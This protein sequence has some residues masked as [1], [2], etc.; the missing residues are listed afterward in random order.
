MAIALRAGR[1]SN[2][3]AGGTTLTM[4]VPTG[5]TD[6]DV[7]VMAI[8]ARG[9]SGTAISIPLDSWGQTS[10]PF[11][12]NYECVTVAYGG[13]MWVAFANRVDLAASVLCATSPDGRNWTI[14]SDHPWTTEGA[15]VDVAYDGSGTWVA[16]GWG[17]SA[18]F[19]GSATNPAGTWTDRSSGTALLYGAGI[20][21]GGGYWVATAEI[22]AYYEVSTNG[23][24]WTY[25]TATPAVNNTK[26]GY[27]G[28]YYVCG[29]HFGG[30]DRG[31][32]YLSTIGSTW[33]TKSLFSFWGMVDVNGA[34]YANGIWVA[35]GADGKMATA[36]NPTGTWTS[37]TSSFGTDEIFDVAY[38]ADGV[39]V[40]VGG[41]GKIATATDPTGTWTQQ[42]SGFSTSAVKAVGHGKWWVI[43]GGDGKVGTSSWA[44]LDRQ[45]S[46]TTLAQAFYWRIAT[47]EPSSYVFT[48]TSNKASGV[49]MSV[50]GADELEPA[51]ER[52][53][54]GVNASSASVQAPA[55]GSWTA[56]DGMDIGLFG[57]AY[58]SSFTPPGSY[59]EPASSDSASTGTTDATTSAGAYRLLTAATTVGAITATAANAA[60]NI[61]HHVYLLDGNAPPPEEPAPIAV[62]PL[63]GSL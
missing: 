58:G 5:T 33:T 12:S 52:W 22:S 43:V 18:Y 14:N 2:N 10:S 48:L 63:W 60:V 57:T 8:T 59:T 11:P 26:L 34:Y 7:M 16:V 47:S 42:T 55:L 23:T 31:V 3:G 38:G 19:R 44:L 4:S 9:G 20:T 51:V 61:G 62:I 15:I 30:S 1:A 13:G 6:G 53:E 56:R 40:A 36:T 25:Y 41:G 45:N 27:D 17:G 32:A 24:S 39:W 46:G 21:Y 37:R 50:S 54:G 29:C 35:Y 28:T 49:I